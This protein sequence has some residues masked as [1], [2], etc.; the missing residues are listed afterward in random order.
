MP[1]K[2]E[3][4]FIYR[5]L[6]NERLNFDNQYYTEREM[7]EMADRRVYADYGKDIKHS[8]QE[9][10]GIYGFLAD[11]MFG[12]DTYTYRYANAGEMTSFSRGFWDANI[13]GLGS[14]FMEITRRFFPNTDKS[15]V[16]YNPL[17]NN[18][19]DWIPDTY[20]YGDPYVQIPKGEMRL[21]GKGYEAMYDLH[22]DEFGEYGKQ[23]CRNKIVRTAGNSLE[24]QVPTMCSNVA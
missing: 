14:G 12:T 10:N 13:G 19:P 22:P 1:N 21:P 15:R 2:N 23:N 4:T 11:K 20:H 9:I 5:N 6:A 17:R 8:L 3:G 24:L 16:S 7:N 18:M